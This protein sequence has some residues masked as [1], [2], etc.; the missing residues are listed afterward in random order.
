[1]FAKKLA[2]PTHRQY[3]L[4][5]LCA[6]L[7]FVGQLT[8]VLLTP[9]FAAV[10]TALPV[11]IVLGPGRVQYLVHDPEVLA[12]K[13]LLEEVFPEVAEPEESPATSEEASVRYTVEERR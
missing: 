7:L 11:L 4:I 13:P 6:L 3:I 2:L 1:M 8:D 5:T 12:D 10:L 9:L